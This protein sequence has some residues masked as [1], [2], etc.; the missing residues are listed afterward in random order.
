AGNVVGELVHR[1]R[2]EAIVLGQR[3]EEQSLIEAPHHDDPIDRRAVRSKADAALR[4][5]E[6]PASLLIKGGCGTPVDGQLGLASL[7]RQLDAGEVEIRKFYRPLQ[8]VGVLTGE[9]DQRNV[10]LV[11]LDPVNSRAVRGRGLQKGD[12]LSLSFAQMRFY[13]VWKRAR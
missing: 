13:R 6:K 12:D 8:L 7:P 2:L 5:A 9:K 11:H 3:V 1:P 10:G 4:R